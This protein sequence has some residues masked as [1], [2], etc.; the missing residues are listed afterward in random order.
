MVELSE[1]FRLGGLCLRLQIVSNQ[2]DSVQQIKKL[3]YPL[4]GFHSDDSNEE[5]WFLSIIESAPSLQ[6]QDLSILP[7]ASDLK[8]SSLLRYVHLGINSGY[9]RHYFLTGND[10][11][12][13]AP[14]RI[15]FSVMFIATWWHAIHGCLCLHAAGVSRNGNGFLFLGESGA[16][17]STVSIMS[18]A[19]GLPVLAEDRVFIMDQHDHYSLASGPHSATEYTHYSHLRPNLRAIFTLAKDR[20]NYIAPLSQLDAGKYLFAAFLQNSASGFLPAEVM[21]LAFKAACDVA[22][23]VPTFE[24]H[25]RKNPDFWNLIDKQFPD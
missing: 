18:A 2:T 3:L 11:R 4:L 20:E 21:K 12:I 8:I 19:L 22:R 10:P 13:L 17:K 16:G 6:I 9:K 15:L 24:L 23:R 14:D 25:F 5:A 7:Q 1:L